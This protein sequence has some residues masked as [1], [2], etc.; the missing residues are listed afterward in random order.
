MLPAIYCVFCSLGHHFSITKKKRWQHEKRRSVKLNS[1]HYNRSIIYHSMVLQLIFCLQYLGHS[2][3]T[4]PSLDDSL[5]VDQ[6]LF[7]AG[8]NCTL[9]FSQLD[10]TGIYYLLLVFR[11]ISTYNIHTRSFHY[12]IRFFYWRCC[13]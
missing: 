4:E 11:H 12:N 9:I 3:L 1:L 10:Y 7:S 13:H 5:W 6:S 2:G 8:F